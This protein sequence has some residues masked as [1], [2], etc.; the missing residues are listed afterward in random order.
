M[1]QAS[2]GV[3]SGR[4]IAVWSAPRGLW[5][6]YVLTEANSESTNKTEGQGVCR[7]CSVAW[8][9]QLEAQTVIEQ[10][11]L[12]HHRLYKICRRFSGM[13]QWPGCIAFLTEAGTFLFSRAS[14][15]ALNLSQWVAGV[16]PWG[17]AAERWKGGLT[18]T[19]PFRA[20]KRLQ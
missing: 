12:K 15:P 11:F 9:G 19:L 1:F 20:N 5:T 4:Q 8:F 17:E 16:L 14:R 7:R 10:K 13:S 18:F 2:D 6:L 3:T